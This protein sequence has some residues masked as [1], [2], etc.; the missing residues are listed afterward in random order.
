MATIVTPHSLCDMS[1]RISFI[2]ILITGFV[3]S[4]ST[5]PEFERDNLYDFGAKIPNGNIISPSNNSLRAKNEFNS[6]SLKFNQPALNNEFGFVLKSDKDG[7]FYKSDSITNDTIHIDQTVLTRNRHHIDL[8]INGKNV[9]GISLDVKL[10]DAVK[11]KS[12]SY[13]NFSVDLKWTKYTSDDFKSYKIFTLEKSGKVYLKEIND[14]NDTTFS[15]NDFNISNN[16]EYGIETS[17]YNSDKINESNIESINTVL[18]NSRSYFNY[19]DKVNSVFFINENFQLC[20]YI[21][22]SEKTDCSTFQSLEGK[23]YYN[24][25]NI[26]I[27]DKIDRPVLI[28]FTGKKVEKYD[29]MSG[30][31]INEIDF[32]EKINTYPTTI[33]YDP[34]I[35]KYFLSTGIAPY[36]LDWNSQTYKAISYKPSRF[37]DVVI[38]P[39]QKMM[40]ADDRSTLRLI[41]YDNSGKFTGYVNLSE[42]NSYTSY[43]TTN[44]VRRFENSD[45]H[46]IRNA[47]SKPI[48]V[49]VNPLNEIF[50]LG[51]NKNQGYYSSFFTTDLFENYL[52]SGTSNGTVVVYSLKTGDKI[53]TYKFKNRVEGFFQ[54]NNKIIAILKKETR[55]IYHDYSLSELP[56]FK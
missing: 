33:I 5:G 17:S 27:N 35:N 10:P 22:F 11:L 3:L 54:I 34:I 42:N 4:C 37:K 30:E 15:H 24:F 2:L 19:A 21:I 16:V 46:V 14:I 52:F 53:N 43:S 36:L 47:R 41:N 18:F 23:D 28:A 13:N 20:S 55:S 7:I 8:I 56:F 1:F 29:L 31:K 25:Y 44:S 51:L 39:E 32:E 50:E 26:Y 45:F 38:K 6:F 49:S 9:H 40:F 48:I 12:V